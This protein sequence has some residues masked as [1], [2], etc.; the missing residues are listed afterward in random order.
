MIRIALVGEIGSGK[1]F[2]SKLFGYP[3]F[4]ADVV[5]SEIYNR[6]KKT[7]NKLKKRLP[8]FFFD[9]PVKKKELIRAILKNKENIKII[10]SI[11]HPVVRKKFD[12]PVWQIDLLKLGS[13]E[14]PCSC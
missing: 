11:V 9:F 8:N 10:S 12:L 14:M 6:D 1:T 3:T 5:V 13:D 2:I 4:N 7:F